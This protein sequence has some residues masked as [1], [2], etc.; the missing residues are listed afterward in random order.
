M[1]GTFTSL[2]EPHEGIAYRLFEQSEINSLGAFYR[3]KTFPSE[4][5]VPNM[6]S[7]PPN[8]REARV[9]IL[10]HELA[11]LI[12]DEHGAWLIPDDGDRPQ[13][14]RRNT[15]TIESRCGQ[16]IRAL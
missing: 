11:H 8:T 10:L 16:Q 6:G 15:L 4:P 12:K 14:S 3:A 9:I 5:S 1:S 2:V 13:I 7:F